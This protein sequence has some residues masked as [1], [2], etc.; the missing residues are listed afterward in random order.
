[1]A[2]IQLAQYDFVGAEANLEQSIKHTLST[3][4][5]Y[6]VRCWQLALAH[7]YQGEHQAAQ[8]WIEQAVTCSNNANPF[9]LARAQLLKASIELAT[10]QPT[11]AYLTLQATTPLDTDREGW[12]VAARILAIQS[13]M[14]RNKLNQASDKIVA[15]HSYLKSINTALLPARIQVILSILKCW[16][17]T[18]NQ[19]D[20]TYKHCMAELNALDRATD[21]LHWNPDGMEVLVFSHWFSDLATKRPYTFRLPGG[22]IQQSV[23]QGP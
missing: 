14:A 12:N 7:F 22:D 6:L 11:Q 15:M 23:E 18:G 4:R 8:H 19:T 2:E 5:N 1:M 3:D 20:V 13:L 9:D 17:D 10:G 16:E 21:D